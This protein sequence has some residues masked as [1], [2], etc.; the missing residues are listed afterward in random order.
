MALCLLNDYINTSYLQLCL[1][2]NI[3]VMPFSN[4][5][6]L[7]VQILLVCLASFVAGQQY[8]GDYIANTRGYKEKC[9]MQFSNRCTVPSVPG[10]NLTYF[11]IA[12]PDNSAARLT[13]TNYISLGRNGGR[14]EGIGIKRAVIVIHGAGRDPGT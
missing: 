12:N 11:N 9:C 14:L 10:A 3:S 8:A 1:D 4:K 13:L 2:D 6:S 5:L 7:T